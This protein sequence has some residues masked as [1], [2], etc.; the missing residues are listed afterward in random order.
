MMTKLYISLYFLVLKT[1]ARVKQSLVLFCNL[2]ELP[3]LDTY[4]LA[5]TEAADSPR[6]HKARITSH[7]LICK[8]IAH[9]FGHQ[10]PF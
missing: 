8:S 10:Q 1:V 2:K 6:T 5:M 4:F 7:R 3:S 9:V